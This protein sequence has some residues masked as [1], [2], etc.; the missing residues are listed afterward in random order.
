[1]WRRLPQPDWDYLTI[2]NEAQWAL[3]K[4]AAYLH[5]TDNET[6]G[7]VEFEQTPTPPS[8]VPLACDMS[9]SILSK[10]IDVSKFGVIYAGAQEN[11]GPAGLTIVIIR[12]DLLEKS[13]GEVPP[14]FSY[15][16]HAKTGSMLNTPPTYS[17]Y[18][19]GL[20]FKWLKRQGGLKGTL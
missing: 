11:I 4:G 20:V 7:G 9:S 14:I 5:Y 10:E 18:M 1:M 16:Q 17:W 13:N 3:S 6:I 19:A 2:P 12:E 15:K 8:D